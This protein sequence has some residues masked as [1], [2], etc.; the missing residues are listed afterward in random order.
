MPVRA[1]WLKLRLHVSTQIRLCEHQTTLVV[2]FTHDSL[3]Y[4]PAR[5]TEVFEEIMIL[6][7]GKADVYRLRR[8]GLKALLAVPGHVLNCE[9][10]GVGKDVHIEGAVRAVS[11]LVGERSGKE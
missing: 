8:C 5:L 6:Q 7:V 1:S 2:L 10:S 4:I 11:M 9:N 3:M